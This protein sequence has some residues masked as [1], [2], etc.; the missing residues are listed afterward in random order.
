MRVQASK[1]G[2]ESNE[3]WQTKMTKS[4][5]VALKLSAIKNSPCSMALSLLLVIRQL[6]ALLPLW[7]RL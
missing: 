5:S 3:S 4:Q 6:R 1:E 2:Q 7:A